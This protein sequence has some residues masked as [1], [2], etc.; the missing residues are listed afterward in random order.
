MAFN[1]KT[2]FIVNPT[3]GQGKLKRE[4]NG[5]H[6]K[7]A[8]KIPDFSW[9]FTR[10]RGDATWITEQAIKKGYD[11][12][13]SVGGDGTLNECLNG[14][15]KKG[16]KSKPR[17]AL[18][19]FPY[20]RGSDFARGLGIP[21][22]LDEALSLFDSN[23]MREVDV[24]RASFVDELGKKCIQHFLNIA[25]VGLVAHVV[26]WSKKSPKILG[27]QAA[28]V[29]GAL[30]GAIEYQSNA[31]TYSVD[32]TVRQE[33]VLN[34]IIANGRFFGSG[35]RAAPDAKLDD[36]I[37]D[38]IVAGEMNLMNF[39]LH[40]PALYTGEHLKMPQVNVFHGKKI[41]IDPVR[42]E[43]LL[44]VEMDGDAV[45]WLP[46]TFEILPKAIKFKVV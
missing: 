22:E 23:R 32:K 18:G 29:Y 8:K 43:D 1:L 11:L 38:V 28:Y 14:F 46:A 35:M 44:P 24:G 41:R 45:G 7:L 4:W 6:K 42:E 17:A 16:S 19:I 25:N 10:K 9:R 26:D 15:I 30:R 21:L 31:V 40:V 3:A 2:F 20:G 5:L 12:I 39:L 34:M 37:L 27:P 33:K 36:G 13:V